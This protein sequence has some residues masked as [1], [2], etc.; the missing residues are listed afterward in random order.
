MRQNGLESSKH[1]LVELHASRTAPLG[2]APTRRTSAQKD[3]LPPMKLLFLARKRLFSQ[4]YSALFGMSLLGAIVSGPAHAGLYEISRAELAALPEYCADSEAGDNFQQFGP[5][6]NYWVGRMGPNFGRIHHYCH[7]LVLLQR[8]RVARNAERTKLARRAVSEFN[9]MLIN[10]NVPRSFI[11][12]PEMLTRRGD[13]AVVM[14]DWELAYQSY[15]DA[16]T[17]KPDY[18]P[19]YVAWANVLAKVGNKKEALITLRTGLSHSLNS[20]PLRNL[21]VQLGGSLKD[22]PEGKTDL[23]DTNSSAPSA[24]ENAASA[25][26]SAAS[27]PASAPASMLAPQR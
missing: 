10:S 27:A 17:L 22:I 2:T 1:L 5:R 12:M 18:W 15:M 3:T 9:F 7:G 14:E 26:E 19:P 13:A 8:A 20:E 21:Y 16:W 4:T 24:P 23:P 11:L 6:Y 25:P